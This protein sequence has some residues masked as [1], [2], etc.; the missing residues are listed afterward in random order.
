MFASNAAHPSA[1]KAHPQFE[2]AVR[3]LAQTSV[4]LES[5][6][7]Y[8]E[9][10]NWGLAC[11]GLASVGFSCAALAGSANASNSASIVLSCLVI[12]LVSP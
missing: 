11:A 1:L 10:A 7:Q 12:M 8:V 6:L 2:E 3:L 9:G 4:P 5:V